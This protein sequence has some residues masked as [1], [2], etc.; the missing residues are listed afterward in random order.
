M[1]RHVQHTC[2]VYGDRGQFRVASVTDMF[3]IPALSTQRSVRVWP[4]PQ[5]YSTYLPRVRRQRSVKSGQ[6]QRHIRHTCPVYGD[7]GQFKVASATTYS[8]YLSCVRRQRSDQ[9][10]QCHR[11]IQHTCPLY[12]DRGQFK[13]ASATDIF[14]I[15]VLCTETEVSSKWPVQPHC[16]VRYGQRTGQF[17]VVKQL[18]LLY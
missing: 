9:S 11:H 17:W 3:S 5:T 15:P 13:V 10:G 6:C 14:S 12:G 8:A 16:R 18:T 4:V 1:H 7:R 2:T